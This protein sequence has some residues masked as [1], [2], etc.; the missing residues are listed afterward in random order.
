M[1]GTGTNISG[2][3]LKSEA[4]CQNVGVDYTYTILNTMPIGSIV[5]F[6]NLMASNTLSITLPNTEYLKKYSPNAGYTHVLE[7]YNDKIILQKINDT[8]WIEL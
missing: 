7:N 2:G 3:A 6:L 5:T 8:D 1:D 4:R